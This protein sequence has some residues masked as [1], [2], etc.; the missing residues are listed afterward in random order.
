MKLSEDPRC[1]FSEQ[2]Q[3]KINWRPMQQQKDSGT[4]VTKNLELA[5]IKDALHD[6]KNGLLI[7]QHDR[8]LPKKFHVYTRAGAPK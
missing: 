7:S 6:S 8:L 1:P 4:T 3:P 5:R 2:Y